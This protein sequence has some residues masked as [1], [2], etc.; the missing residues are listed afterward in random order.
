MN[1]G[2]PASN[3]LL[4]VMQ[5]SDILITKFSLLVLFTTAF[6]AKRYAQKLP[7]IS[8]GPRG[9]TSSPIAP[10][11]RW[12][13]RGLMGAGEEGMTGYGFRA[14]ARIIWVEELD[15]FF[16]EAVRALQMY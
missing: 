2:A 8:Q 11:L 14:A 6:C 1:L 12:P 15:D 16:V 5:L 10:S 7:P 9:F 13:R 3:R 4:I